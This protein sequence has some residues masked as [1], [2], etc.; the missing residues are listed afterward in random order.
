VPLVDTHTHVARKQVDE[1]IDAARLY[2][3][4]KIFGIAP[5]DDAL[6]LRD[7]YPGLIEPV[8]NLAF[9]HRQAHSSPTRT[10]RSWP[11]RPP[12]ACGSSNSG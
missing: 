6:R 2:G 12:R 1:L 4:E 5:L 10:A 11:E 7:R 8:T 3:V 9:D